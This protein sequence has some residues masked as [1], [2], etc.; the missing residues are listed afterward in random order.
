MESIDL[1]LAEKGALEILN[2]HINNLELV[3]QRFSDSEQDAD[4][5]INALLDAVMK[6]K[7]ARE[8]LD[9]YIDP[10]EL[11][12]RYKKIIMGMLSPK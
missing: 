12:F 2:N 3:V 8:V 1:K 9:P 5:K 4:L 7:Q 11:D 10:S 6:Y